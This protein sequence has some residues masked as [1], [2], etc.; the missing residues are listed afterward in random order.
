MKGNVETMAQLIEDLT[1]VERAKYDLVVDT[2]ELQLV[3]SRLIVRGANRDAFD[4][5]PYA[6]GQIAQRLKIRRDFWHRFDTGGEYPVGLRDNLVNGMWRA[7]PE[8]RLLRTVDDYARAYVSD[9]FKAI[10]H[11]VVMSALM[12]TME[13]YPN[14]QV[15]SISVTP[16]KLY[17]QVVFPSIRAEVTVGDV[18]QSGVTVTNS[19]IG[20]GAVDVMEFVERLVCKNGLVGTSIMR[21]HHVGSKLNPMEESTYDVFKD[22]TLKAEIESWRLILRDVFAAAMKPEAFIQR[23]QKM[24]DAR[25]DEI[26]DP[27]LA[28]KNVTSRFGIPET[29]AGQLVRYMSDDRNLNRYGLAN[30]LTWYAQRLDDQNRQFELEKAGMAVIDLPRNEWKALVEDAA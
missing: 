29:D 30:S 26:A 23:V 3:G 11:M 27:I 19:E 2:R 8:R 22:D 18:V 10:D 1:Q 12:P 7:K 16:E 17:F 13:A 15:R 21:R 5:Q 9:R 6:E 20:A 25:E 4:L 24:R 14:M 28:A